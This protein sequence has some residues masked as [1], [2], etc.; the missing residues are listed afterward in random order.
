ML[1]Q[2]VG[3]VIS[4]R[5][6]YASLTKAPFT[7]TDTQP[8][9][10]ISDARTRSCSSPLAIFSFP[11]IQPLMRSSILVALSL[12]TAAAASASGESLPRRNLMTAPA[13]AKSSKHGRNAPSAHLSP[14][15]ITAIL[16]PLLI[17]DSATAWQ[18]LKHPRRVGVEPVDKLS[19]EPLGEGRTRRIPE[20][21]SNSDAGDKENP[22]R[23]F[24][25]ATSAFTDA[26]N[27]WAVSSLQR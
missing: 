9:M 27:A 10:F 25:S 4:E 17:A 6:G 23:L 7:S 12:N 3:C 19:V 18:F 8:L 1:T 20:G 16:R 22:L 13:P 11:E 14:A 5:N 26:A 24:L 2:V 21:N 15:G